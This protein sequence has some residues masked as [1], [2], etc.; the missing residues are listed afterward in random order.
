MS[1]HVL[2]VTLRTL[3]TSWKLQEFKRNLMFLYI[4]RLPEFIR[5]RF[6]FCIRLSFSHT[7]IYTILPPWQHKS[8]LIL[9][10]LNKFPL[11]FTQFPPPPLAA[12]LLIR[13]TPSEFLKSPPIAAHAC[14]AIFVSGGKFLE[15]P[16]IAAHPYMA[17]LVRGVIPQ[18]SSHCSPLLHGN[19][20]Q[21]GGVIPQKSSHCSPRL[22][23]NFCQWGVIPQKSSH[24]SPPSHGNFSQGCNSSKFL[25]LLPTL[26]WEY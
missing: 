1:H 17:I 18:N 10:P 20:S 26:T 19:F 22:H 16:L 9:P 13:F 23:G 4:T 14:M 25:P 12:Q 21:G 7:A 15:S 24:C 6:W 5:A 2:F 8:C 11:T 3:Q